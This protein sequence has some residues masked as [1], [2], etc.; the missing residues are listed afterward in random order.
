MQKLR[1]PSLQDFSVGILHDNEAQMKPASGAYVLVRERARRN[2]NDVSGR[3]NKL[4]IVKEKHRLPRPLS[5]FAFTQGFT[6]L[7]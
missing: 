1:K 3:K 6:G 7:Q 5:P 4:K 2:C